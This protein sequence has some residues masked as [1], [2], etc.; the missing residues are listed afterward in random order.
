[1]DLATLK[2]D[3]PQLFAEAVAL[4]VSQERERASAH[5]ILGEASGD[6]KLAIDGIKNGDEINATVNAKHTAAHMKRQETSDR[7]EENVGDL[8]SNNETVNDD[9]AMAKEVSKLL[10]G[11]E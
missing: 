5:L 2:S 4:G 6:M 1:M 8:G 3:H 10:G 9:E 11:A 7:E